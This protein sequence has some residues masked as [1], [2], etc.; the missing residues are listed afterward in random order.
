MAN[1][2]AVLNPF[3]TKKPERAI[4]LS[5][6][7]GGFENFENDLRDVELD[8][9]KAKPIFLASEGSMTFNQ[10]TQEKADVISQAEDLAPLQTNQAL[11]E[12]TSF[13]NNLLHEAPGVMGGTVSDIKDLLIADI[14]GTR[15]ESN[16]E[17]SKSLTPEQ[18]K[19]QAN[20]QEAIQHHSRTQTAIEQNAQLQEVFLVKEKTR[21]V[22]TP[23]AVAK[24]EHVSDFH[25]E[26]RKRADQKQE[27]ERK[28]EGPI[29]SP[30]K[31]GNAME[32]QYEGASGKLGSG[33]ASLSSASGTVG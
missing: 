28:D 5:G 7:M 24:G 31:Q 18:I 32:T 6:I 12:A 29:K 1:D 9:N 20:V 16:Q 21:V 30:A 22:E 13:L 26:A 19:I 2:I 10:T 11:D 17:P 27:L 4:P 25:L 15:K 33:T 23:V 14:F 8:P 3:Q